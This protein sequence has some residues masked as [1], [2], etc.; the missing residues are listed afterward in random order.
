MKRIAIIPAR[1]A[2]S[3]FPKKPLARLLGVPMIEHVYRR[4]LCAKRIDEAYIATCDREIARC[5]KGFGAEV[6]MT[7]KK[8][9]RGTD[10]V[11]EAAGKVKSD[12]V[13]NVQG[14]EPLVDPQELDRAVHVM[15]KNK[16]ID[17]LNLVSRIENR[18]FFDDK[19]VIKTVIDTNGNVLYFSR[20]GI[21]YGEGKEQAERFKQIGIYAFRKNFLLLFTKWPE[22]PLESSEKID[23]LRIIERGHPV[24]A[25]LTKDMVSVDT[26][27]DLR[28]A[29]KLLKKDKFYRQL[30]LRQ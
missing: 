2:S 19:N 26:S 1:L 3:R 10:R 15:E 7:S 30:F 16:K 18:K 12:I 27:E 29:E 21:P 4:T 20:K 14:D 9:A 13:L 28:F 8:H 22:T 6:I 24:K 17:C 5:A 11:A 25:F 23:M